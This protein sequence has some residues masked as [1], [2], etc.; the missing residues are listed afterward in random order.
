MSW[1][2]K[3]IGSTVCRTDCAY[4]SPGDEANGATDAAAD[5]DDGASLRGVPVPQFVSHCNAQSTYVRNIWDEH[6]KKQHT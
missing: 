3:S 1:R 5:D 2:P 4:Q 6:V